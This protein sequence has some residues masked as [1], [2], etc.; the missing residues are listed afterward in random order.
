MILSN[1]YRVSI[2]RRKRTELR[3]ALNAMAILEN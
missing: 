3:R 2:A 1:D